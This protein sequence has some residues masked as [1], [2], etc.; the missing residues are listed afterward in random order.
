MSWLK[1]YRRAGYRSTPSRA[2]IVATNFGAPGIVA[3]AL[4]RIGDPTILEA[5]QSLWARSSGCSGAPSD[6]VNQAGPRV[7]VPTVQPGGRLVAAQRLQKPIASVVPGRAT[8]P[9]R[10]WLNVLRMQ[11]RHQH[12]RLPRAFLIIGLQPIIPACAIAVPRDRRCR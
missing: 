12:V 6:N 11:R 5:R 8:Q 10:R 9:N 7:A 3:A 1:T 2:S 4:H